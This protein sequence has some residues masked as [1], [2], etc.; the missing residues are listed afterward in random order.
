MLALAWRTPRLAGDSAGRELPAS[1]GALVTSPWLRGGVRGLGLAVTAYTAWAA[2]AGADAAA[3]PTLGVFYIYLWVGMVPL[4]LLLG[5][6][7][8]LLSPVRT[9]HVVLSRALGSAPDQ[10][11][12][13]YPAW[14]GQ[15]PAALGLFAFVWT[16]LVSP[17]AE[18]VATVVTWFLVY[19]GVM[20]VGAA[21]FGDTFLAHADPFEVWFGLVARLSPWG[22]RRTADGGAR[23][24]IRSPLQSLDTVTP[25]PGLVAVLAVLLGST[26][27]DS[28]STS[29]WWLR[30]TGVRGPLDPTVLD[31][32]VLL[33][34]VL[35]VMVT[36]TVAARVGTGLPRQ[37]RRELPRQLAHSLVPIG[38]GYVFAHYLSLL[39]ESGQAYLIFL[40]DPLVTGTDDVLGTADWTVSYFLSLRPGLLAVLK[41]GFVLVGHVLAVVAAHDRALRLLPDGHRVSGQVGMLVLMLVY[42]VGG[43]LLLFS[44]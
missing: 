34:F 15:W 21:V 39:L 28:F 36:F 44:A 33:G 7:W 4:S 2:F 32:L 42:T 40:S 3:N 5:D 22:L 13:R 11:M 12:L 19:A 29:I 27:Y 35:V 17:D 41:V 10:G 25:V 31:T 23:V 30:V 9:L 18:L 16:E 26:A 8:P 24:V 38:V 6:V 20:L 1:V 37:R 43:L 14:L